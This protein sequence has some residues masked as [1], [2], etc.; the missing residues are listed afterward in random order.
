MANKKAKNKFPGKLLPISAL[1]LA[2]SLGSGYVTAQTTTESLDT[3][4]V[5]EKAEAP[6]GKDSYRA[7]QTNIGKGTQQLRDIPQSVTVVTEKLIDD[8]N[9][10]TLKETLK[11]TAGIS[12]QAAE[13]GEEDIR[14]RGFPLSGTGDIFVDGMRD[15][16]FYDRD[17]FNLDRLELLRGSASMLFGR[18]STGG[19][20]NQVNKVP[21]LIDEHQVDFTIGS[22][23]Y[24]RTVGDF[25]LQTSDDA[26]LRM[27]V[28]YT[29]AD[30]NGADQSKNNFHRDCHGCIVN[31]QNK[32]CKQKTYEIQN[33]SND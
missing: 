10:D 16:A 26:A 19:A 24:K 6:E 23:K 31:I 14:L 13:G 20:V 25:N 33:T 21:R 30:N 17:T 1:M 22:H 18:G 7:T 5:T 4:K 32:S 9:L 11:N 12:F 28:M 3:V 29:N 2:G 8:R 27:N 15:P